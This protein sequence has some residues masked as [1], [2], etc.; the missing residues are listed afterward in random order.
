MVPVQASTTMNKHLNL[1][2]PANQSELTLITN[3]FLE[4]GSTI[5]KTVVG[6]STPVSGTYNI[7]S[8]ICYPAQTGIN[9]SSVQLLTHGVGFGKEYWAFAPG[10][11]YVDTAAQAG[12][13]TFSYDRL[14]IGESEHPDALQIV[15]SPLEVGIAHSLAQMLKAGAFSSTK[16]AK[17]GGVGHSFGSFIS[18]GVTSMYPSDFCAVALTGFSTSMA[19]IPTFLASLDLAIASLNDPSRFEDLSSGYIITA[20]S[21]GNQFAFFREP[22][23]PPALLTAATATAQT[24]TLGELFT[25]SAVVAPAANYTGAIDLVDGQND[26]P[27]CQGNCNALP[28]QN[29]TKALYPAVT[30]FQSYLGAGAGHALNLH[31]AATPAFMQIQ[32]F[33]KSAAF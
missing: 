26:W 19:G 31:Y 7:S 13:T 5:M 15:Q 12:Y 18:Q 14:G 32:T 25:L 16:F 8:R 10:Y 27:F 23:Y 11:S 33:F 20:N 17:V 9:A 4:A 1:A 2:L 3:Q 21:I 22:N 29:G 30:N 24:L 6:A 28:P